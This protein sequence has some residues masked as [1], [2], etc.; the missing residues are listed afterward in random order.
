MY[1]DNIV[2]GSGSPLYFIKN[3]VGLLMS[4]QLNPSGKYELW[5]DI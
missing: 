1:P 5:M 4:L 2:Q 3:P